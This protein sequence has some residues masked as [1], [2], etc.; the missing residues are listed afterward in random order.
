MN[1]IMRGGFP[2]GRSE[3]IEAKRTARCTED[4]S[5]ESVFHCDIS[6][7]DLFSYRITVGHMRISVCFDLIVSRLKTYIEVNM[8]VM[9]G[10]YSI[11]PLDTQA[12]T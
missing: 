1:R 6:G 8:V 11:T 5:D 9:S 2:S 12:N 3:V 4:E 7:F 10:L